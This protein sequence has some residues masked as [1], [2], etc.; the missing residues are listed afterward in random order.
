MSSRCIAALLFA[1]LL[2]RAEAPPKLDSLQTFAALPV[3]EATVFK[4]GHALLLHRG[5]ARVD[6]AGNVVLTEL[7]APVLGTLF[8]TSATPAAKLTGTAARHAIVQVPRTALTNAELLRA[9]LGAQVV[10]QEKSDGEAP[11]A[12][13]TGTVL[14][15]PTRSAAEEAATNP[16][17]SEPYLPNVGNMV[18]LQTD[19]GVVA[20]PLDRVRLLTFR[21]AP[22]MQVTG[23]ELRQLLTL[24]LDWGATKPAATAEIALGYVQ[25]GLR[26][27]PNY[28]ITLDG[29]GQAVVELQATLVNELAD[30]HDVTLNLVVGAP[31]IAF[32][33]LPDP[34]AMQR[35][36]TQVMNYQRDQRGDAN[37]FSNAIMS[38]QMAM[39]MRQRGEEQTG[40]GLDLGPA[41]AGAEQREDLHVYTL[42]G[43]TLRRG[44]RITLPV[45]TVTLNHTDVY[46]LQVPL[47][48]PGQA[49]ERLDS[50][51]QQ[52]LA[53]LLATSRVKHQIRL[54]N[55]GSAPLTT[56]PALIRRGEQLLAQSLLTY[57]AVGAKVDLELNPAVNV[58]VRREESV[59]KQTPNAIV[60]DGNHFTRHDLSGTLTLTNYSGA[61][62]TLEVERVVFGLAD[63]ADNDG[64]LRQLNGLENIDRYLDLGDARRGRSFDMTWWWRGTNGLGLFT[65]DLT[66]PAGESRTLTYTWHYFWR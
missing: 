23:E 16:P 3:R 34:L 37:F 1:T 10:V 56:A 24:Q 15:F 47:A 7:P 57:T 60:I 17:R 41:V 21:Q 63:S 59:V 64:K 5:A 27:I 12:S 65:W 44:E 53:Q 11:G 20:L 31:Q 58:P 32:A 38:Q 62:I 50:E 4:D 45:S 54:Q 61:P 40:S 19:D 33:D 36:V 42:K 30:L 26:W 43:I 22:Q 35:A 55:S 8:A 51:Q 18:L 25:R 14:G 52:R 9:N 48:P 28:R 39:P 13:F 46:T 49:Y 6:A 2:L 66:L 29:K